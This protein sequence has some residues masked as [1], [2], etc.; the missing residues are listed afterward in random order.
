MNSIV[1]KVGV[2]CSWAAIFVLLG[3]AGCGHPGFTYP[4][5]NG[6]GASLGT[7]STGGPQIFSPD[8][9]RPGDRVEIDF[10]G[11]SNAPKEPH[12]EQ[13]R[14]DGYIQPPLLGTNIVAA[15]KT[16]GQLQSELHDLYVP[17]FFTTL[18]VTVR[19]EDRYFSVGGQVKSP[20]LKIYLTEMTV[21][22]AI[23]AA[24]DFTDFANRRKVEI[25]RK[26]GSRFVVDC[27]RA[28]RHP[29][30]DLQIYPGDQITVPQRW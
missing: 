27:K 11:N 9:L 13:I 24:G 16:I 14:D 12:R 2:S 7:N 22:K 17:G 28:L 26:D 29:K 18:T 6:A 15:G 8:M 4:D 21:T 25:R 5:S 30:E 23:Q 10:S 20:G 1:Y 19:V 3:T